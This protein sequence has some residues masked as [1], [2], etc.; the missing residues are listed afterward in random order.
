MMLFRNESKLQIFV[1]IK[2]LTELEKICNKVFSC[3]E[4]PAVI[5]YESY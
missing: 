4:H 5:L 2:N 1:E 3:L